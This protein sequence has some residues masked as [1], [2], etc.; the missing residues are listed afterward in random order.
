[1][2]VGASTANFYPML[3]EESLELL[4]R[5]GFQDI[6]VFVNAESEI[7]NGYLDE[8]RRRAD[9]A[10]V[11]IR[12]LHP[13]ISA[14]EPYLLFSAY[15]RRF[16]DGCG[17][18]HR[19]FAAAER[20]GAKIVV[21]HGDRVEG[22]LPQEESIGRYERLYDIGQEYGVTLA[23]ENVLRYR[24]SGLEY[25]AAM[26]RQLGNKAHFVFDLKQSLRCGHRPEQVLDVM[27]DAVCHVHISDHKDEELCLVPGQG[28]TDYERLF[29]QLKAL[30]YQGGLMLELYRNNFS[31][32]KEL[33]DGKH[34]LQHLLN[35]NKQKA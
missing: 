21:M 22:V 26:R 4:I 35:L 28:V 8:L 1:M 34:F 3:T 25:L 15:Q 18:Y 7:E 23:Q 11:R 14:V 24:S 13:Y 33:T 10:Q 30:Q 32:E 31:T 6:E 12:S 9:D 19:L 5:L 17:I 16:E 20:L 27:G 2:Y 29:S